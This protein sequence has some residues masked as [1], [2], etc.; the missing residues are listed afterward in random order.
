VFLQEARNINKAAEDSYLFQKMGET[1]PAYTTYTYIEGEETITGNIKVKI[2]GKKPEN[3]ELIIT[4]QGETALAFHNGKYC[5]RKLFNSDEITIIKLS[6]DECVALT[7][8]SE[9]C[10][11]FDNTIG[12]I[13]GYYNYE[14]DNSSNPAC[15]RDV[16][17]PSTIGGVSVTTISWHAF[18][19]RQLASAKIPN[20]VTSIFSYAFANN[21]LTS[22]TIPNSVTSLGYGAFCC[23]QLTSVTIPNSVT[24]IGGDGVYGGA[25]SFNQLTSITI[26]NSVTTISTFAFLGNKL[27]SVTIPNSVT[28]IWGSAFANNQLTSVYIQGK[29]SSTGFTSYGSDI[30]GW[31]SGYNDSNITWNAP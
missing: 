7:N 15:P 4:S 30:W 16:V 1:K 28:N 18:D 22:L 21:R 5:A 31:A 12:A 29:S 8:T 26:P 13:T 19:N 23:N 10:F 6:I 24:T 11:A 14:N 9:N 27:T 20:S 3:G 25:F 17:I 2:T